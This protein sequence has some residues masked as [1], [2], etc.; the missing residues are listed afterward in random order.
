MDN[1]VMLCVHTYYVVRAFMLSI[2]SQIK[3]TPVVIKESVIL[4]I[5]A[6]SYLPLKLYVLF[7]WFVA[8]FASRFGG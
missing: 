8:Q 1:M 6:S 4:A 7:H 2:V 5:Y 3:C